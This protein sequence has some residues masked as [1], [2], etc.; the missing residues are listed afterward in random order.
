MKESLFLTP[1]DTTIGFVSQD[2]FKIDR[3]KKRKP[4]KHYIRVVD[5]LKTLKSF[6]RVPTSHKNRLRRAKKTTFI[7]PNGLSF[8]LVKG[9]EHN[10]LLDRLHW[11]YSSSANLSG[12]KYDE[13]YAK[14][15][16]EVVVTFP[17]KRSGRASTIYR[18]GQK[19]M[20]VI[21]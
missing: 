17:K 13:A 7:M 8:R 21:R 4:N 10:L 12:A 18:L 14:A 20:K 2:S 1:T 11:L 3:A 6:T 9:T 5:S 16:A 19:N 15:R